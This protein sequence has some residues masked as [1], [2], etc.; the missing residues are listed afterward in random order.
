MS[1]RV[2]IVT[3]AY[4]SSE[5]LRDL[6]AS[7][8]PS[9]D[10][11]IVDNGSHDIEALRV[12]CDRPGVRLIENGENLGFGTACNVGAQGSTR[13]FLFFLNPDARLRPDTLDRLC[14][15]ADRYPDASAFN[16]LIR[17]PDGSTFFRRRSVLLPRSRWMPRGAPTEDREITLLSGAAIFAR[18]SAFEAIGGFDEDIF[19]FHEDDDISLRLEARGPLMFIRDAV[20][21]HGGG[22][23]SGDRA[24][25]AAFKARLMGQS[26]VQTT[27]KHGIPFARV[28][29]LADAGLQAM[30]VMVLFSRRKRA[31]NWAFLRGVWD[32]TFSRGKT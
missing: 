4:N 11:A 32:E 19:L 25:V 30:N 31:K 26:R 12:L 5:V 22:S 27:I 10:L 3:V 20:V 18:R 2:T 16:P 28:R 24:E 23:T 14:A 8:P 15:A 9:A 21:I 6:I 29:N 1:D 13:D 7:V 17:E